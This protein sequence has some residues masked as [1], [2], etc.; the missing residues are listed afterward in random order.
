[1]SAESAVDAATAKHTGPDSLD[2]VPH[3]RR[4]Y[5]FWAMLFVFFG[6]QVPVSYFLTGGSVTA[7]LTLGRA[8]VITVVGSIVGFLIL[9]AVGMIGWQT[10]ASTMACTR[11]AFGRYGSALPALIAFIELTGWDSVHVQ[12]AGKLM[13]SIGAQWGLGYTR[14]YSVIVGLAI[15]VVVLLGHRVLRLLERFLVPVVVVLVAMALYAVLNGQDLTRL[16]HTA[17]KGHLTTMLAFDAMFISA[18][19]WVP[20]VSDY[21]RYGKS[22][23]SSFWSAFLSIPIALFMLFVGQTAAVGLGNPNALIAMVHHGVVFGLVAFFVAMFATIA[24]AALIMYS[25]SMSLLNVMPQVPIRRINYGTGLVVIVAAVTLNLL[26]NVLNWLS[27]QG[28]MLIPLFAIV[29]TDYYVVRKGHYEVAELFRPR[30]RYWGTGG[31]H[32]TGLVAWVI[33]AIAYEVVHN[34]VPALGGGAVCFVVSCVVYWVISTVVRTLRG[35]TEGSVRDVPASSPVISS[36]EIG[37]SS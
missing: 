32:I 21:T 12:L 17:G 37:E 23:R 5:S 18:L 11:P 31:F 33:G 22:R 35:G 19:T 15:V 24:T 16:W 13:G 30:G 20:M 28:I 36:L 2:A 1:M 25:A 6:M 4:D 29:L 9:G 14:L 27:F 34:S 7:G 10:G 8:F 26:G 3:N